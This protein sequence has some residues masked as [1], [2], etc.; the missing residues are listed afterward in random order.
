MRLANMRSKVERK[1][2]VASRTVSREVKLEN[3]E[4][5]VDRTAIDVV[6]ARKLLHLIPEMTAPLACNI[7]RDHN[8]FELGVVSIH[9]TEKHIIHVDITK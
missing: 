7:I 4:V 9:A 5:N 8:H 1:A 6:L 2:Q 3:K